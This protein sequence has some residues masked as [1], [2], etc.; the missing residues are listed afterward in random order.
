[1]H[2]AEYLDEQ[3]LK[4]TVCEREWSLTVIT[5]GIHIAVPGHVSGHENGSKPEQGYNFFF[6]HSFS[7]F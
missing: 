3:K 1:M 4:Q 5:Q 6:V 2:A 7:L